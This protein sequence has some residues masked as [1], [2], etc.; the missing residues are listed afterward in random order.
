MVPPTLSTAIRSG[1]P[2]P[3][4]PR[5]NGACPPSPAAAKRT[6]IRELEHLLRRRPHRWI[7]ERAGVPKS[8]DQWGW[9]VDFYPRDG[10][11]SGTA[12]S[13][14]QARANFERAWHDYLPRCSP[15]DFAEHRYQQ[16]ATPW[17]YRMWRPAAGCRR[18][19]RKAGRGASVAR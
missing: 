14:D 19:R 1:L 18:R 12:G 2:V 15:D 13:F 7:G 3:T 9:C 11:V 8:V 10:H 17:K 5:F 6:A 16:A 4:S